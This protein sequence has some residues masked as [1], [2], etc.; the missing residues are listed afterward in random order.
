MVQLSVGALAVLACVAHAGCRREPERLVYQLG[1]EPLP[2]ASERCFRERF[3]VSGR[4][5]ETHLRLRIEPAEARITRVVT[6]LGGDVEA[7]ASTVMTVAGSRFTS[8]ETGAGGEARGEGTVSGPWWPWTGWK[9]VTHHAD[10]VEEHDLLTI[11]ADAVTIASETRGAGGEIS[12]HRARRFVEVACA[13][14]TDAPIESLE[15]AT[16][17]PA[18]AP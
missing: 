13:T 6:E 15:P 17:A 14:M 2:A 12:A 7:R 16:R 9:G 8:I 10:G 1:D 18:T 3:L 4:S 5:F 11:S